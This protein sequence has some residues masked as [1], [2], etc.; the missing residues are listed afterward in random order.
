MSLMVLIE[1]LFDWINTTILAQYDVNEN[2]VV[3]NSTQVIKRM[4][5]KSDMKL[6]P[7]KIVN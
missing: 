6:E 7:K 3:K 4:D 5:T 1:S 2:R